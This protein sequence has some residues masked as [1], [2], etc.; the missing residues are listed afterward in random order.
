MDV[1]VLCVGPK[2]YSQDSDDVVLKLRAARAASVER[3][4]AYYT[5]VLL[6]I[7]NDLLVVNG[8]ASRERSFSRKSLIVAA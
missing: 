7:N 8:T 3:V 5:K 2:L 1:E 4:T 6:Y